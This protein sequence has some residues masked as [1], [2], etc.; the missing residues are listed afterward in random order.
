MTEAEEPLARGLT[1]RTVRGVALGTVGTVVSQALLVVSGVVVANFLLPRDYAIAG[2]GLL[3]FE[4]FRMLMSGG[5]AMALVREPDLRDETIHSVFWLQ[6]GGGGI[7]GVVLALLSPSLSALYGEPALIPVLLVLAAVCPLA[8]AAAVPTMLLRRRMLFK[9][10][11]VRQILA[12]LFGAAL[13]VALAVAG[14]RHWAVL[15]PVVGSAS[16]DGVL[17]AS[18]ARYWP[19]FIFRWTE[20]RRIGTFGMSVLGTALLRFIGERGDVL[21]LGAFWSATPLGLYYFAYRRS[22]QGY[23]LVIAQAQSA[24]Y[25]ALS[26]I[27][28]DGARLTRAAKRAGELV[29]LAVVPPYVLALVFADP[30]V[31]AV[32]GEQWRD[33]V[34]LFQVFC[35]V[36]LARSVAVIPD[37][38]ALALGKPEVILRYRA[39]HSAVLMASI[40]AA[41]WFGASPVVVAGIVMVIQLVISPM[42]AS[43]CLRS[44]AMPGN[45]WFVVSWRTLGTGVLVAVLV[46][47]LGIAG[48][49]A[50]WPKTTL[51]PG[52]LVVALSAFGVLLRGDIKSAMGTVR[53]TIAQGAATRGANDA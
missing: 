18:L 26:K 27:Q 11:A 45:Q 16:L 14:F 12:T 51:G 2:I 5:F 52:L 36:P 46:L 42:E 47:C 30:L 38:L 41:V 13:G 20:V 31:P 8:M 17:G 28:N 35:V 4:A 22:V 1:R 44:A 10:L 33:A 40:A 24:M 19:R 15:A 37:W 7:V 43:A 25:P 21:L 48:A 49:M 39:I 50:G 23:N 6:L 32:F 53:E 29:H 3:L 34:P 9:Q